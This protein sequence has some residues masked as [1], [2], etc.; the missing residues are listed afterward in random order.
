MT[1]MILLYLGAPARDPQGATSSSRR[2]QPREASAARSAPSSGSSHARTCRHPRRSARSSATSRSASSSAPPGTGRDPRRVEH[3][4]E[5]AAGERSHVGHRHDADELAARRLRDV[6]VVLE[7]GQRATIEALDARLAAV[8]DQP[9]ETPR[10]RD[11]GRAAPGGRPS[12]VRRAAILRGACS[13]FP[14]MQRTCPV[15]DAVSR[16]R[17]RARRGRSAARPRDRAPHLRPGC[18]GAPRGPRRLRPARGARRPRPRADRRA[19]PGVPARHGLRRRARR[20]RPGRAALSGVRAVR[21]LPVAARRHAS[22]ARS[23]ARS[24][25]RAARPARRPA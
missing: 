14:A 20:P 18:A 9:M 11:A 22:P 24:G 3:C 2:C 1:T 25:G 6:D 8:G 21:R 17:R 13:T 23:E 12:S 7:I 5:A 16:L 4:R 19:A 15:R 10:G